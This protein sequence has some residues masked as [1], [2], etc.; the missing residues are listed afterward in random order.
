MTLGLS[1]PIAFIHTMVW[2]LSILQCTTGC[3]YRRWRRWHDAHCGE[4]ARLACWAVAAVSLKDHVGVLRCGIRRCDI[5]DDFVRS[6]LRDG[7]LIVITGQVT[8]L[9]RISIGYIKG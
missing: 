5:I 1:T 7:D 6:H 3:C 4:V 9:G 8:S 2:T